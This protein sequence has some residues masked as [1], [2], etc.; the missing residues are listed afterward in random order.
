MAAYVLFFGISFV[1]VNLD[2]LFVV[3]N[4]SVKKF[5]IP[6]RHRDF[7]ELMKVTRSAYSRMCSLD[8][9]TEKKF[10]GTTIITSIHLND[11]QFCYGRV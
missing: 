2:E 1:V 6:S 3:V 8:M 9:S 11:R 4:L 5:K 7:E 10:F